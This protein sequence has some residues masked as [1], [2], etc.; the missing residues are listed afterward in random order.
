MQSSAVAMSTVAL[1]QPPA[2]RARPSLRDI[3]GERTSCSTCKLHEMCLSTGLDSGSLGRFDM[4]ISTHVRLR[5][6]DTLY[7]AGGH[8][9][10][11]YGIRSGSFKTISLTENGHE[12]IAGY[13]LAGDVI[14]IDGMTSD[15]HE[16]EAIALED[17]EVCVI[18][19]R[20]FEQV[21][22]GDGRVQRN[23]YRLLTR[24]ITR[25]RLQM[26]MLGTMHADQRL[27][28]FLLDLSHRYEL[29]GYS[30]SAF[31]LRMTREEIGSYLGLKLETV[32][33]LL[34]RLQTEDLIRVAGRD[35][36]LLDPPG[37]ARILD[38]AD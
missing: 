35:I 18:P 31:V 33:R 36:V 21:A 2:A 23:L 16:C 6:G 29:L 19:F 9:T 25:E 11:L 22:G 4:L 17:S 10:A 14:G 13:H 38:R 30:A 20:E 5:K 3:N 37:L 1:R 7:R 26:V 27:V 34:S 15:N 32:S 12:Q 24:E 8:F 28:T